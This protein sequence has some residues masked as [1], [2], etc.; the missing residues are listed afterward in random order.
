VSI[1]RHLPAADRAAL[2]CPAWCALPPDHLEV[3]NADEILRVHAA[4]AGTVV[5]DDPGLH[6]LT[7]TVKRTAV[8]DRRAGV[9]VDPA[10]VHVASPGLAAG[11]GRRAAREW[12][13]SALIP[14][15]SG[16]LLGE[17]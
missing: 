4:A 12:A 5:L 7:V 15:S 10:G 6:A 3:D 8:W 1:L 17:P 9:V 11:R 2:A 14:W 16:L 13:V